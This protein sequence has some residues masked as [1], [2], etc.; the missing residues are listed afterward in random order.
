V[1]RRSRIKRKIKIRTRSR[2]TRKS[3]IRKCVVDDAVRQ[4]L[5]GSLALPEAKSG[6]RDLQVREHEA[7]EAV[8]EADGEGAGIDVGE[9]DFA[10]SGAFVVDEAGELCG[11]GAVVGFDVEFEIEAEA[12]GVPIGGADEG[13]DIIDD[14]EFGMVEGRG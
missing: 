7:G 1:Q 14:H 2:S 13:P 6:G 3:K 8:A 10:G 12:A 4:S 9:R 5:G 11:E